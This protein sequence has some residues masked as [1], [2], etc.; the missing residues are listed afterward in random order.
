MSIT[1]R[2]YHGTIRKITIVFGTL[3]NNMEVIKDDGTV[4]SVPLQYSSKSKWWTQVKQNASK[5]KLESIIFPA[6]GYILRDLSYDPLRKMN[7][8]SKVISRHP[9]DSNL[10]KKI[11]API[12]YNLS[13]SLFVASRTVDEGLQIIEQIV[14]FF[15]PSFSVTINEIS[16]MGILKDIPISLESLV[17]DDNY[18]GGFDDTRILTWDL[19]FKVEANLYGPVKDQAV[20]KTVIVDSHIDSDTAAETVKERYKAYID[21]T[22]AFADDVYTIVEDIALVDSDSVPFP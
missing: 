15:T 21:P 3:F 18:E 9:T 20:I 16:E 19:S 5:N 22:T 7:S 8:L 13:F 11:Y 6:M 14:P 4:V 2:F 17:P 12:P 10:N 1:N